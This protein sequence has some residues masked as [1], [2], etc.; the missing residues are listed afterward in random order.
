M[1]TTSPGFQAMGEIPQEEDASKEDSDQERD[2]PDR[3]AVFH[4]FFDEDNMGEV[5]L[6]N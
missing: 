6:P 3:K 5:R 2:A 4:L 1:D